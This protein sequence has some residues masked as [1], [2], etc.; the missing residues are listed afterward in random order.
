MK[1]YIMTE[2]QAA[3]MIGT[4]NGISV[5]GIEQARRLSM[6]AALI[7]EM[8]VKADENKNQAD[9]KEEKK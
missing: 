1:K 2:E 6:V 4:L 8:E 3:L 5:T 7:D 9:V